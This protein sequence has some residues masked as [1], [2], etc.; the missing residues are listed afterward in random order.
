MCILCQHSR[1]TVDQIWIFLEGSLSTIYCYCR[2]PASLPSPSS[3]ELAKYFF[4]PHIFLSPRGDIENKIF[5]ILLHFLFHL[6]TA[7]SSE[8]VRIWHGGSETLFC[9]SLFLS[10]RREIKWLLNKTLVPRKNMGH[11]TW[12]QGRP[13]ERLSKVGEFSA[14]RKQPSLLDEF[15]LSS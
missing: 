9:F 15:H 11:H 1:S 10:N 4:F 13:K 12:Y 5:S 2:M 8:Y 7:A 14:E 3:Q 6:S